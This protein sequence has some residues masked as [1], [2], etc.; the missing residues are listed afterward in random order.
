MCA[1][2]RGPLPEGPLSKNEVPDCQMRCL[3]HCCQQPPGG[4]WRSQLLCSGHAALPEDEDCLLH[5]SSEGGY[6]RGRAEMPST[7]RLHFPSV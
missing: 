5:E 4:E 6:G 1:H 3:C 2:C 7:H